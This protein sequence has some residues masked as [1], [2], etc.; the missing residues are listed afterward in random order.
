MKKD[1]MRQTSDSL[2]RLKKDDADPYQNLANAI[3]AVAADDY[4][5]ALQSGN[6]KLKS[7]LERFFHSAWYNALT[8]LDADALISRLHQEHRDDLEVACV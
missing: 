2:D 5:T 6:Q 3:V 4:R 8:S 7:R 1:E